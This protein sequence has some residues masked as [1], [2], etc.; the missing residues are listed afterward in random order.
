MITIHWKDCG[1]SLNQIRATAKKCEKRIKQL[2]KVV[3][4]SNYNDPAASLVLP[5]DFR[6]AAA[7]RVYANQCKNADLLV[8]V[9]I[10]GSNLGTIAV[11]GACLGEYHNLTGR[12]QVLYADTVDPNS[13]YHIVSEV[14]CNLRA[15]KK[16]VINAVSKSGTTA[17]TIANFEVLIDA[18]GKDKNAFIVVTTDRGSELE[19]A[20]RLRLYHT[21]WVPKQVGGRFSVFSTVSLFPLAVLGVNIERLMEGAHSMLQNCL[22]TDVASNPALLLAC[23]AYLNAKKRPVQDTFVF[24]NDLRGYGLWYRQLVAETVGKKKKSIVPT[25]SVGSTDL[26]SLGQ[27]DIAGADTTYYR[28]ISVNRR[29]HKIVVPR[30]RG[31]DKL[32]PHLSGRSYSFLMKAILS[33]TQTAFKR[34]KRPFVDIELPDTGEDNVGGMLQI[35]MITMLLLGHLMKVNPFTQPAV[36]EYKKVTRKILSK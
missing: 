26:H 21:L 8:V 29:Y 23:I 25:V 14:K 7:A 11:Q 33:G 9:G 19:K 28:F 13:M 12:T 30:V 24:S 27:Q 35:D 16:V 18:V 20:A 10:G 36:E 31:L 3:D 4:T 32:V 2:R 5:T 6:N 17:E 34:R 1:F 15:G 22:R